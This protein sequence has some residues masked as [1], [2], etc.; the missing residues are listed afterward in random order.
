[1]TQIIT[2]EEYDKRENEYVIEQAE[3]DN[4]KKKGM[5]GA[6]GWHIETK[7]KFAKLMKEQGI[8]VEKK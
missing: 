5:F 6:W 8:E 4:V 3:K 1:M 2:K 7:R